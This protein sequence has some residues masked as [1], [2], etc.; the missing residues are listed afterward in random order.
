MR[1]NEEFIEDVD[2]AELSTKEDDSDRY[3]YNDRNDY[4]Y[5]F[6]FI[7]RDVDIS[8]VTEVADEFFEMLYRLLDTSRIIKDYRHMFDLIV[9]HKENEVLE[10][11]IQTPKGHNVCFHKY[12]D[13]YNQVEFILFL[14]LRLK[15]DEELLLGKLRTLVLFLWKTVRTISRKLFSAELSSM[16]FCD[17]IPNEYINHQYWIDEEKYEMWLLKYSDRDSRYSYMKFLYVIYS[18]VFGVHKGDIYKN[19]SSII[20]NFLE[21]KD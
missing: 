20:R 18:W 21:K 5:G 14:H 10:K 16:E 6:E 2:V 11:T 3:W 4:T 1:I 9:G 19:T 13:Q 8:K 12:A 17:G 15:I 7:I